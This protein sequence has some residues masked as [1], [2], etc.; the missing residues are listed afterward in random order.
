MHEDLNHSFEQKFRIF[1]LC[2]PRKLQQPQPGDFAPDLVQQQSTSDRP[3]Y[4]D[5]SCPM[6]MLVSLRLQPLSG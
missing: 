1:A 2:P 4:P 6:V 5:R 3:S